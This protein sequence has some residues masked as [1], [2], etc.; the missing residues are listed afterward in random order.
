[1]YLAKRRR[2]TFHRKEAL[3]KMQRE[4]RLLYGRQW[5]R[6][7]VHDVY[8]QPVGLHCGECFEIQVGTSYLPCRI[9]MEADW[10]LII[11][12]ST[13]FHLHPKS[14]YRVRGV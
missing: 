12:N 1:M 2:S 3:T 7:Y 6:W 13:V 14:S 8:D 10:Y 9:E 5:D 4:G 11:A